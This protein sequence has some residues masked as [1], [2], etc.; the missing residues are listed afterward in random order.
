MLSSV[1]TTESTFSNVLLEAA[2]SKVDA[3]GRVVIR[4]DAKR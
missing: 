4:E 1:W 3:A 2:V